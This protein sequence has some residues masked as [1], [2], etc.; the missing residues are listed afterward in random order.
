MGRDG[1]RREV[2]GLERLGRER[3]E[4]LNVKQ[5]W[6]RRGEEETRLEMNGKQHSVN[7]L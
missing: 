6:G 4:V 7:E 2:M 3:M 1:M 5:G